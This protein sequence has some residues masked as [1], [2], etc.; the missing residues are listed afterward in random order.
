MKKTSYIIIGAWIAGFV[1]LLAYMLYINIGKEK[2][3][4]KYYLL[5]GNDVEKELPSFSYLIL[6]YKKTSTTEDG[7]AY[8]IF[9]C[10][11][12]W[13]FNLTQ[14]DTKCANKL[15]LPK[16]VWPYLNTHLS[17]DTLYITFDVQG[18]STAYAKYHQII[19]KDDRYIGAW[20][21]TTNKMLKGVGG[22]LPV[23]I[24]EL[25]DCTSDSLNLAM[26][27]SAVFVKNCNIEGFN[28]CNF[29]GH[30]LSIIQSKVERMYVDLDK[31]TEFRWNDAEIGI[32][33]VTGTPPTEKDSRGN[34]ELSLTGPSRR[35]VIFLPKDTLEVN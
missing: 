11:D 18:M 2:I 35:N 4:D 23:R 16:E 30:R 26:Q 7:Y 21:L 10:N 22:N 32:E 29:D 24:I 31:G 15:N 8:K 27:T 5:S 9:Y 6:D 12:T 13:Q 25:S 33:Y 17:N 19:T 34:Y 28:T 1:V 20:T 3:T 14:V